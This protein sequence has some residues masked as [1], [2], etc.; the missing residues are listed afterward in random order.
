MDSILKAREERASRVDSWVNQYKNSSILVLKLNTVGRE[1]NIA[2][3]Q[4]ILQ[5]FHHQLLQLFT[6][7]IVAYDFKKSMDGDYFI[8]AVNV[9]GRLMKE[10]T[11]VLED[12]NILGRLVDMDVY[13]HGAISRTDMECE[14]RKCLICDDY[15]H[16]CAR[17]MRH[18]EEEIHEKINGIIDQFLLQHLTTEVVKAIYQELDLYPKFGLVS[19]HD[20]GCHK[21]M[22]Y[23]TFVK[24]TFALK[25]YVQEFIKVGLKGA[26]NPKEL[27][28]IGQR[29]EKAMFEA[30]SGTNT[31]KGLI[32]LLGVFLDALVN[33]ILA[34]EDSTYLQDR[35][36]KTSS[37]IIGE[38]YKTLQ[39]KETLSHGDQIYLTYGL[40]GIR[41]E[42]LEGLP[43][44]FKIPSLK[45]VHGNNRL[46][47]YLLRLMADLEDTAIIHKTNYQTLIEV[48]Q[49]M[50][51][52][53]K[54]GGFSKNME[55]IHRLSEEY[56]KRSISPGGSAD[57]LVIKL[58]YED[59]KLFLRD[60]KKE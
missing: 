12:H 46:H 50:K 11:I 49:D 40:K 8:Y 28:A 38:Y 58:I 3:M 9:K 16:I 45:E 39:D 29:A 5:F 13:D 57:L 59:M 31:H 17:S 18:K 21:D 34:N 2:R 33:T 56:K 22:T 23:E 26:D 35:I 55:T 19:S 10:R 1:K 53:I 30:T 44:I 32:F 43:L 54:S 15:A 27:Q 6:H 7:Q 20:A 24:S 41:G 52:I 25:P 47:E 4:F 60:T 36:K 48:Q 37:D 14:L 42:A 51:S